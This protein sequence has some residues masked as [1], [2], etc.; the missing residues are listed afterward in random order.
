[1]K[2]ILS[3][4]LLAVSAGAVQSPECLADVTTLLGPTCMGNA[5]KKACMDALAEQ[6]GSKPSCDE[7]KATIDCLGG[8]DCFTQTLLADDCMGE[9]LEVPTGCNLSESNT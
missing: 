9:D 8:D 7:I 6:V 3:A 2:F 1:M 5:E 4:S